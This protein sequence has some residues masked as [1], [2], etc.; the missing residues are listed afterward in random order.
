MGEDFLIPNSHTKAG[1]N[2]V[3]IP[4]L[5]PRRPLIVSQITKVPRAKTFIEVKYLF[6]EFL[7]CLK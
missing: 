6:D 4:K 2:L 1:N 7:I 3:R 5:F